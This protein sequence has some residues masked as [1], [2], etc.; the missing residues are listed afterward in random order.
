M[1]LLFGMITYM[2]SMRW[3]PIVITLSVGQHILITVSVMIFFRFL[4]D[5]RYL[6]L[7]GGFCKTCK[8]VETKLSGVRSKIM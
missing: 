2:L 6:D 3:N 7:S 8:F 5:F 1:Y 4:A